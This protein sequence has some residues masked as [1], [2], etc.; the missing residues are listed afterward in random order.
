ML[1]KITDHVIKNIKNMK[2]K[3]NL[4]ILFFLILIIYSC[5][6]D[7]KIVQA[8]LTFRSITFTSAYGAEDA[9]IEKVLDGARNI[10]A[11]YKESDSLENHKNYKL[12]KRI[13][14]LHELK[15]LKLPHIYL[16]F[17]SDSIMEVHITEKEYEKIK[18][19][20]HV[21]LLKENKKV[22]LELEIEEKDKGIYFSNNIITV[23]KA[24][25]KSRSNI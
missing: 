14:R 12:S 6:T 7:Q 22:I 23:R 18:A 25:G 15:L 19:F 24:K 10:L 8:D 13:L 3:K 16:H 17:G 5:N 1:L 9:Q 20:K 4:H 2:L 21:D 11:N